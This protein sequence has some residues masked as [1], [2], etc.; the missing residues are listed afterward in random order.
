MLGYPILLHV[1]AHVPVL[2]HEDPLGAPL[3]HLPQPSRGQCASRRMRAAGRYRDLDCTALRGVGEA[4]QWLGGERAD[5]RGGVVTTMR[6]KLMR[7]SLP[8]P[9]SILGSTTP[10]PHKLQG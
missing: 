2:V 5:G 4:M 9:L 10:S 8:H 3:G 6:G 7:P 1:V